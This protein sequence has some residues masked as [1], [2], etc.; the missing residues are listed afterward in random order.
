MVPIQDT[1]A[2]GA[3]I[4]GRAIWGTNVALTGSS[5]TSPPVV[6]IEFAGGGGWAGEIP[7][8]AEYIGGGCGGQHATIYQSFT[9]DQAFDLQAGLT[10][11][12][13]VYPNPT[14]YTVLPAALQPIDMTQ[15]VGAPMQTLDSLVA[16]ALAFSS[17]FTYP[18][19][20]T[21]TIKACTNGYVWLD[22]A[23]TDGGQYNPTRGKLLGSAGNF[24]ARF[25]PF[26]TDGDPEVNDLDATR[27]LHVKTVPETSPGAG[28]AV[29]YMTWKNMGTF[30]TATFHGHSSWT[31]QC[32]IHQQTGVVE[33]RY[34]SMMPYFSTK[35][36][37]TQEEA[38]IGFTRGRIS[39]TPLVA[40]LDPQSRDLS[41][42]LPFATGPEGTLSNVS[43]T[44]VGSPVAGSV[45]QTA[46]MFGG[47]SLKWNVS[48]IP[49]GTIYASLN[50]DLGA[51][52]PGIQF[53]P[54][55]G[56]TAPNC[57]M[58]TSLSPIVLGWESWVLPAPN[59]TGV[60]ALLIPHGW[61]GAVITAQAIGIDVFGGPFLVPWASNA[62]KYTVGLD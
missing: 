2:H 41:H 51:S 34:G 37:S 50:L 19:G 44:A 20:S 1:V 24:T 57:M 55:F 8:R 15:L 6:G 23:M 22:A 49:A 52:Q 45:H 48:N 21:T 47:Q 43:L 58:S 42:E 38:I 31:Y 32:V 18:G 53:P 12:P 11:I 25:M 3:G 29:C 54:G 7:A 5:D 30:K 10:F 17:P 39:T 46:R 62:I 14:A 13:D 16:H 40:S 56:I 27:G 36:S 60:N 26:W 59:V 28:N 35:W 9:Q 4:R 61:E 33:F